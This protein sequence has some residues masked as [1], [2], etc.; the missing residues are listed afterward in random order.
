M[1]IYTYIL[2]PVHVSIKATFKALLK[3]TVKT[4][5][6]L[7]PAVWTQGILDI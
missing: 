1:H 4:F 2:F 3:G 7:F 6:L 5:Q